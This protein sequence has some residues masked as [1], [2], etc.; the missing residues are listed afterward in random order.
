MFNLMMDKVIGDIRPMARYRMARKNINIICYAGDAA[1]LA[2]SED[3]LQRMLHQFVRSAGTL[4]MDMSKQKTKCLTIS[5]EPLRCKL[6]IEGTIIEQAMCIKYL[7]VNISSFD[8][9]HPSRNQR[10]NY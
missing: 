2:N 9:R 8:P 7:G 1:L 6:E 4:H 10:P 3:D 5:R